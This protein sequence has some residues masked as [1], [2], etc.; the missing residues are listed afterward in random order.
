MEKTSRKLYEE[1]TN[2]AG[3]WSSR[4]S[5]Y[6]QGRYTSQN[7]ESGIIEY[8]IDT[9]KIQN[10]FFVEFGAGDGRGLSNTNF[11]LNE[12]WAGV[13]LEG[14]ISKI[15]I[16]SI[17][18]VYHEFITSEN[19]NDIFEKYEVP[20]KIGVLSIDIDGDD[21]YVFEALNLTKYNADVIICEFNPGLPNNQCIK[22]IEQRENQNINNIR[23]G[24]FGANLQ[25]LAFI[26]KNK[27][28]VVAD[29]VAW[30]VIFVREDLFP[31]LNLSPI[32][33]KSISDH[34]YEGYGPWASQILSN[35]SDSRLWVTR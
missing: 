7:G 31:G 35:N 19:I 17:P 16:N 12:G 27:G 13:F 34:Y 28:Y 23:A 9:L 2:P 30:N 10:K 24:Y 20:S 3:H 4:L 5:K 11:L 8:I 15:D 1:A 32:T 25:E 6:S 14:D 33:E 26:A 22:I 21:A 18:T 29:I